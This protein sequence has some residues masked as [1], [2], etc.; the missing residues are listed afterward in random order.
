MKTKMMVCFF[1]LGVVERLYCTMVKRKCP[2]DVMEWPAQSPDLNPIENVWG[3]RKM[4][5]LKPNLKTDRN[6]GM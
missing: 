3:D 1:I 5:F 6:C 2:G 4:Q